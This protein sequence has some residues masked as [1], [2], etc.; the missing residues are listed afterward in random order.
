MMPTSALHLDDHLPVPPAAPSDGAYVL[1]RAWRVTDI[2]DAGLRYLAVTRERAIGATL[3]ELVPGMIG[4]EY[5][6]RYRRAMEDRTVQEFVGPSAASPGTWLETRLFPVAQGLAV[7]LR[8][9]TPR[10]ELE[11]KLKDRERLL[12]A[13]FAQAT[14]GLAQTDLD[15]RFSLVNDC[16]CE[17]TGYTREELLGLRMQ[18]ITHP[19]DLPRN[20]EQLGAAIAG[21]NSFEI[22]K[23]YVRPDGS[24]VWVNN[25]VAIL[26]RSDGEPIGILAVAIDRTEAR[27]AE[28]QLRASEAR[29]RFISGLDAALQAST[30]APEALLAAATLL[31]EHLGASRCAYADVDPDNDRFI[32]RNDYTAAG[33][34]S[35]AGSYSLDLFGPRAAR[36]MRT[37][38][39]LVVRHVSA[40]LEPHEGGDMFRAI[41]IE[42]IICCPLIKDG[43]L[44]AMMAVH[45]DRPRDWT[46]EQIELVEAVVERC[47]DHV[48]RA[49]AEARLRAS[50]A[51][52]HAIANSIDQM[53]WSTRADGFHDYFNDRWY[54]FTG[55]AA[56]ATDGEAWDEVFHPDDRARANALWRHCLAS[57]EPYHVE[58]RLRHH[59]DGYRWVIGRA[60]PSRDA[61]GAIE[62]WYGTCTDIDDIVRAREVLT[63]SREEMEQQVAARTAELEQ[64]HEQLRQS[65]KMEALGQLT[66]GIAHDFNNLLTP[67]I[68]A[69]D[70]LKRRETDA[71]SLRSIEGALTSADRAR[72]LIAR[73]LSFARKQR[74]ES[75]DVPVRRL[76]VGTLDLLRRSI[77][78]TVRLDLEPPEEALCVRVDPNQL[79]LALL[80][81]AVNARDAMPEGGR[82]RIA[83]C[84]ES[85]RAPHPAALAP[86]SYVRIDVEDEG[87]GMSPETARLAVEPFYS[88]KALG[89]GTGLGLSM[90]HGLAAQSGGGL[91][92]VSAP[93]EGT[94]VSLW[95]PAGSGHVEDDGPAEVEVRDITPLKILLV[96]DEDLVRSATADMLVEVGHTVH[97][98]HSGQA[99]LSVLRSDAAYDMLV[100]DYAMPLM[101]G[102]A[103]IR[104]ARR[105][106]PDMPALLVTGY[107][108]AT[109]DVPADVPRIEKPFRASELINRVAQLAQAKALVD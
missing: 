63:R 29:L 51:K 105:I 86:G 53:V 10:I 4:T 102:A 68:G 73:L 101:S 60:Q 64:A 46:T 39:T 52:F 69:L 59:R 17:L 44:V 43:R 103:L 2:N 100:T 71:R 20:I 18:E 42:A 48:Q 95:L 108:S 55:A 24:D 90:V 35:S 99:A 109:T 5:E 9:I 41:G 3:W 26:R 66:G 45:Q 50:E 65:Q 77:G 84:A 81:L 75:R 8:D 47:W 78:P 82:L 107:A 93:G 67:I 97:Q 33:I 74:L 16:Y 15:G 76:L 54:E 6:G 1:D 25:S 104:D 56:G 88:T 98:A 91:Q 92:I 14:A 80:N 13:I 40:E 72:V 57:G 32:I 21:G 89:K 30:D 36:E 83:A 27:R 23:R 22:E 96:D 61:D 87:H 79:E 106:A 12:S 58:Y 38:T 31:A 11:S 94:R 49:G 7:H 70:L 19:E 37:G 28:Q 85:V 62:R 34:E